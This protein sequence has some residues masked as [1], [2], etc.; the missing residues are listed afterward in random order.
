MKIQ[1][2]ANT[3]GESFNT[4]NQEVIDDQPCVDSQVKASSSPRRS[5]STEYKL[6]ILSA[7]EACDNALARGELLRKEGLYSSRISTWRKQR[8]LGR[9]GKSKTNRHQKIIGQLRAEN[10]QLK[11]KL[12]QAD[13]L[14]ELQKKVSELFGEHILPLEKSEDN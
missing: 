4:T 6:R 7:Y 1:K 8:D 10:H 13:A 11:K 5:Y 2:I 9:L 3:D 14:I 12:R